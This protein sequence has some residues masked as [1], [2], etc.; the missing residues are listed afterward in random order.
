MNKTLSLLLLLFSYTTISSQIT[1]DNSQTAQE[2]A[3]L[4]FNSSGCATISNFSVSG[5]NSYASFNRNGSDFTFENGIVL[6]TGF[7]N[8]IPGPNFS[9]SDD[10]LDT[11]TD[12]DMN[13]H[14]T[15]TYNTTILEFDFV[16]STNYI[17]FEY[18]FTSEEYQENDSNTCVYSDVFAFLIKANSE[19]NYT[20]I[21]LVPNTNIPVQ[22]TTIHPDVT[23]SCL[24]ENE[25]Y[26]GSW[27]SQTDP[28]IPI[29]F[30]G[31]TT[32]LKAESNVIPGEIYHIKLIIADHANHH[33]DSAVFLKADS[34]TVGTNLGIDLLRATNN[35]LCGTETTILDCDYPIATQYNWY[36]DTYPYDGV[37]T[38]IAGANNQTYMWILKG[39]TRWKLT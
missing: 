11:P 1:V 33:Y 12:N 27:N 30:N 16:P 23:S 39:N 14:F 22:V 7:T 29:N 8:N 24:A 10:N 36:V 37:F 32:T 6:S 9:L 35:A 5:N 20:N 4:L 19:T 26:F 15:D 21:A 17:S 38:L 28:S 34:F 25:A 18:L 2:L 13:A 31:Q 3:Q